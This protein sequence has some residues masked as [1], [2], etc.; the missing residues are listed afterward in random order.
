[1]SI[2]LDDLAR[3]AVAAAPTRTPDLGVLRDRVRQRRRKRRILSGAV[4]AP[5]LT[6]AAIGAWAVIERDGSSTQVV[7]AV[8]ADQTRGSEANPGAASLGEFVWPAPPRDFQ[9]LDELTDRFAAEVLGWQSD[10]V[11]RDGGNDERGPQSFTLVNLDT[12]WELH[13]VA[14]PTV[15]GWGF[16]QIGDVGV[17]IGEAAADGFAIRFHRPADATAS[18]VEVRYLDGTVTSE[19]TAASEFPLPLGRSPQ[20]VVSVLITHADD[21]GTVITAS[22]GWFNSSGVTPPAAGEGAMIDVPDVVGLDVKESA[23]RL[24]GAGL[25]VAIIEATGADA[26][27]GVVVSTEPAPGSQVAAGATITLTIATGPS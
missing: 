13:V 27:T 8:G 22:G 9:D 2:D 19:T 16:V 11:R 15:E 25:Q 18:A 20:S 3:D 26:P 17:S 12:G 4:V 23:D 5:V 6:L 14:V 21:T 7:A 10:R 1:M 24:A